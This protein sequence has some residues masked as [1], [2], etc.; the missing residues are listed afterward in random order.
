MSQ[1]KCDECCCLPDRCC[2]G[3][4]GRIRLLCRRK[5]CVS[6][7]VI[8]LVLLEAISLLIGLGFLIS[9]SID[10]RKENIDAFN[11][12]VAEWPSHAPAFMG[13]N[14]SILGN[15]FLQLPAVTKPDSY[16]DTEDG[17]QLPTITIHYSTTSI[18]AI[19]I[20]SQFFSEGASIPLTLNINGT[21]SF[22]S[23]RLFQIRT[24]S[25]SNGKSS[26]SETYYTRL[27]GLCFT[28]RPSF[29]ST[30]N[31]GC[32]PDQSY[33]T[34]KEF[35]KNDFV[36]FEIPIDVRSIYD[37]FVKANSL[38]GGSFF[39][40]VS[41]VNKL[42]VGCVMFI[43]G[44]MSLYTTHISI[45]TLPSPFIPSQETLSMATFPETS[46]GGSYSSMKT[47]VFEGF[48]YTLQQRT[49][50]GAIIR[51]ADPTTGKGAVI[52]GFSFQDELERKGACI[53]DRFVDIGNQ[54]VLTVYHE[55]I[56][57]MLQNTSQR[58]LRVALMREKAMN[59]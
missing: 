27:S 44:V 56:I 12:V 31:S 33:T 1:K 49:K 41:M 40:G 45:S 17:V 16:P 35:N 23:P 14:V 15:G 21:L 51:P 58:P 3:N 52:Y 13:L 42:I 48:L 55:N 46:H 9:L 47:M 24:R 37:P 30:E 7:S 38:T 5:C 20:P 53:G 57:S 6:G 11:L 22:V 4:S 34:Y 19:P 36:S 39:F 25:V 50:I 10:G 28:I 29:Q 32:S 59:S 18:S 43:I 54:S 2:G 8:T 26:R